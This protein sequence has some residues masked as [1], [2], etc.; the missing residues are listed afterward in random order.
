LT[1]EFGIGGKK[2]LEATIEQESIDL[3]GSYSTSNA[4]ACFDHK[5]WNSCSMKGCGAS[6]AG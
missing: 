2:Y 3:V 5:N 1:I 6:Q 4:I